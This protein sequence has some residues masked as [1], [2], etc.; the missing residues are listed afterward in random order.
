MKTNNKILIKKLLNKSLLNENLDEITTLYHGSKFLFQKF[1]INKV[2]T[3]QRSQ[4]F[5]YGL[6]FTSDKETARFYANELSNT[7]TPLQKYEEIII[8]NK[9]DEILYDYIKNGNSQ[10]AKRVLKDLINNKVGDVNEWN[11]LLNALNEVQRYGYL[12]TVY[13][14]NQ[15]FIDKNDYVSLKHNHNL[16]DKEMVNYLLK[17]GYNGIKYKIN[18]FGLNKTRNFNQEYNVVIFDTSIIKILNVEKVEFIG[19]LKLTNI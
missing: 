12:Y 14:F 1:D 17:N 3:G 18:S 8:N 13:V 11:K 16:N 4:D 6:Y 5:G 9:K 7:K 19:T 2:N 15:K 10:S